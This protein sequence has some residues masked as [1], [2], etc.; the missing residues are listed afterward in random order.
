MKL[1]VE[2]LSGQLKQALKPIYII[3]GDTHL[4]VQET[5][6]ALIAAARAQ[7]F[8]EKE[9][10]HH[11]RSFDW[12]NF[13]EA[14]ASLSLFGDKKI[15]ELR[16]GNDKPSDNGKK[17]LLEYAQ[18]PGDDNVLIIIAS[19]IDT[20]TQKSK[21]FKTL[22]DV[23]VWIQIWP[24][25]TGQL[26]QWI[27]QRMIKAGLKPVG[28]AANLIADRVE[29]NLLA[30]SQEIEKLRL[31]YGN[32][33]IDAAKVHASVTVASR[34]DVFSLIDTALVGQTDKA[35]RMLQSIRAEGIDATVVLWA[36]SR[37]IRNLC[38]MRQQIEAGESVAKVI[39]EYRVWANRKA[40]IQNA[41]QRLSLN[42]LQHL[43]QQASLIDQAIKGSGRFQPWDGL[44]S[45]LLRLSGARTSTALLRL[46][47]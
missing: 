44:V 29:G 11:S 2:Q 47:R 37:E 33:D 14:A 34:F 10:F 20:S 22:E 41:L 15:L 26:P 42:S 35:L 1:K 17:A 8:S 39:Q 13:R 16:L 3:S 45:V 9:L 6:D 36:L 18:D 30:A 7:G 19:K 12:N 4:L 40:A 25:S 24:I 31:L 28:D 5:A 38:N 27:K 23:S 21:W 43:L 32:S 46:P